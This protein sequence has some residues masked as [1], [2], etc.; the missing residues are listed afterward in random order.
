MQHILDDMTDSSKRLNDHLSSLIHS[1]AKLPKEFEDWQPSN[2]FSVADTVARIGTV[3]GL[4]D[5]LTALTPE[6]FALV[7]AARISG[8]ATAYNNLVQS[9][10]R[11]KAQFDQI[12]DWGGFGRFDVS[13]GHIFAQNGNA[14]NAKSIFDDIAASV[15]N[16]LEAHIPIVATT[17]PRSVGT[18][19]AAARELRKQAAEA[20]RLVADLTNQQSS[21]AA[22]IAATVAQESQASAAA[23]ESTRLASDIEQTRKTVDEYSIKVASLLAS[24]ETVSRHAEE[25]K[26]EVE[27]Y[28]GTYQGFQSTL[29]ARELALQ[30]GNEY[31]NTLIDNLK[32][33]QSKIDKQIAEADQMLGGA[34]V[35]G[36]SS[37]YKEQSQT[38]SDQM[39]WARATYFS[40][41]IL[42]AI[43]IA[44]SLNAFGSFLPPVIPLEN[45]DSGPLAIRVFAAL[46][47]RALVLLPSIL[48]LTFASRQHSALFQLR[49]HY[50]HKYNIAASV[51]GFKAQ[52]PD[53]EQP[54]AGAVFLELLKNPTQSHT[55]GPDE[56]SNEFVAEILAPAVQRALEQLRRKAD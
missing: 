41:I 38:V 11:A 18:F 13:N 37:T 20:T 42:M 33:N 51:H 16:V 27:A 25:L 17:Q 21:L 24:V 34:T 10:E 47:S 4:I 49:E 53:Y 7:P 1:L 12:T 45:Q 39:W 26:V 32:N 55:S 22:T 9:V 56:K 46:G 43:S 29:E 8:L 44:F 31:L 48:L 15:D 5:S 52:A 6:K 23:A 30:K 50:S 14:V 28:E 2:V 35:A 54:I 3:G 36:L 19:V 40:A